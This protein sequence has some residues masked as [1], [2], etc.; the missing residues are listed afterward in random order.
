LT[1]ISRRLFCVN[2]SHDRNKLFSLSREEIET[3]SKFRDSWKR[4][5]YLELDVNQEI[6]NRFS[7]AMILPHTNA[8]LFPSVTAVSKRNGTLR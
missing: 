3:L 6:M 5:A 4:I 2:N 1:H 8:S 7:A